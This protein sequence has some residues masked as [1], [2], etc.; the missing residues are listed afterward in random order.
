MKR[1]VQHDVLQGDL[2]PPNDGAIA[3]AGDLVWKGLR[4]VQ[5]PVVDGSFAELHNRQQGVGSVGG[6]NDKVINEIFVVKIQ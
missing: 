5:Q 3:F 1:T 4:L 2:H 6:I